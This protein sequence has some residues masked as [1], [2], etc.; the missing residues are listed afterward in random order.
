[1]TEEEEHGQAE[2]LVSNTGLVYCIFSLFS[3]PLVRF[4]TSHTIVLSFL[5]QS[6][7]NP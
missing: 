6:T 4:M 3:F 1:M 5:F 2:L 7:T